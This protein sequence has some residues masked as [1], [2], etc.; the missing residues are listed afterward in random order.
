VPAAETPRRTLVPLDPARVPRGVRVVLEAL[1]GAGEQAHLVGG[2][3]RDLLLGAAVRD[4]D[5][6]TSGRP[7]SVLALFPRAVPIG[8]RHGTVMVPTP[9]GPVDVTSWRAGERIEHDLALRDLT[10]NALAWDPREP[11]P[12]DPFG[13]RA[14]LAAGRLRAVGD[15][16]DRFAEDALRAL[17]VA[18]LAAQLGF[19]V[20]VALEPAMTGARIALARVARERVRRELEA[21]LLAPHVEAGLALLRR[22]GIEADLAPGTDDDAPAVAAALPPDLGLR[23]AGW[24]RGASAESI[25]LRLRFGRAFALRVARQ[26]RLHPIEA[27]VDPARGADVRRLIRRA[28]DENLAALFTLR[29][30]ELGVRAA[31]P[32]TPAARARLAALRNAVER[33]RR[34][35]HLA[36]RRRDLALHGDDVI[37]ILGC[38]PGREVGRALD[39]LADRAL[40]DPACNTPE[41]LEA[42]LREWKPPRASGRGA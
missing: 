1:W 41:R 22:T 23:L 9:D 15:A 42:L 8:L 20:D 10:V 21:L 12:V 7:E 33:V 27:G 35:G 13:G 24:L 6:A 25:L 31:A 28:G 30:A 14:D 3:V 29:E 18:R 4:F 17:R 2:C 34:E 38:S 39:F 32:D 37:R 36:L 11:G 40:E 5:V 19:A 16:R 26:L